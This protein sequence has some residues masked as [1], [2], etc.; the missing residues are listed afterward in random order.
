MRL[1]LVS[2]LLNGISR[3]SSGFQVIKKAVDAVVF[4]VFDI[5]VCFT[6]IY[7]NKIKDI[8]FFYHYI[9]SRSILLWNP[10]NAIVTLTFR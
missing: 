9:T 1:I 2:I 10:F 5:Y 4:D 6:Q 3:L 8:L 7:S